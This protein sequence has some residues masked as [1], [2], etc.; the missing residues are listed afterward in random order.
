MGKKTERGISVGYL[1][2]PYIFGAPKRY[3]K[4]REQQ[5]EALVLL[6]EFSNHR[7][8][9]LDM[10]TGVG[11]SLLAYM[12]C[13]MTGQ[14]GLILT[15]TKPLEDKYDADVGSGAVGGLLRDVRGANNYTCRALLPGGQYYSLS[16]RG[17]KTTADFG[18]CKSGH[19][20][21]LKDRGCDQFDAI[22]DANAA[23][24]VVSNYANWLAISKAELLS[25]SDA[26][27]RLGKF[28]VLFLDE[29]HSA[30]DQVQKALTVKLNVNDLA[31]Y[32]GS[33]LNQYP[34]SHVMTDWDQWLVQL[35]RLHKDALDNATIELKDAKA[36]GL[37]AYDITTDIWYL[38]RLGRD[39][40]LLADI[41]KDHYP[42]W[43][44]EEIKDRG[45]WLTFQPVWGEKYC[46]RFLFR[47]IKKIIGMSATIVPYSMKYLG[48]REG[49][50]DFWSFQSPFPVENR[51]VYFLP[52]AFMKWN[53]STNEMMKW[54][55]AIDN[56][57]K[58]FGKYKGIVHTVSYAR[59]QFY[60]KNSSDPA[61]LLM[62][63]SYN[64]AKTVQK[65]KDEKKPV[66]LVS[67]TVATGYDFVEDQ[68]RWQ[69]IG[70]VP[71]PDESSLL[72]KERKK[73]D[74]TYADMMAMT[75]VMQ[76]AGRTTRTL[77]DWSVTYI[78]DAV[79]GKWYEKRK[80]YAALWFRQA[81]KR[82]T[83]I[84]KVGR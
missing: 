44:V 61:R 58:V 14:R 3:T 38:K 37:P 79:W 17:T 9:F 46:E 82:V 50:F 51:P 80:K 22:R 71:F 28:D 55:R 67:P 45:R 15:E 56:I 13:L 19:Y 10:P 77:K 84:S 25:R 43:I 26:E 33:M 78:I 54:V 32:F 29:A 69:V 12:Y 11:K 31:K 20:C 2:P 41:P 16:N 5:E 75:Y 7:F 23:P 18:P 21:S 6:T 4:W 68:A 66:V 72:V 62:N 35:R 57:G 83:G 60:M 52:T 59:A 27:D 53:M 65:F 64:T 49:E 24:V 70:K 40:G 63:Q 74:K 48:L 81:V 34:K 76:A 42:D 39:L 1:P 73:R 30:A 36:S 47:G 8:S